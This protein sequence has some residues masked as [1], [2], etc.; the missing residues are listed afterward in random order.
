MS[1]RNPDNFNP[2]ELQASLEPLGIREITRRM[3]V[4]PLLVDQGNLARGSGIEGQDATICC[5]C[6]IPYE[7]L[8]KDG[9][10]P[11]P[12]VDGPLGAGGGLVNG[13]YG[14]Y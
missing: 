3:E 13:P 6:K 10:F 9:S 14:L 5:T 4:S 11:Y 12:T 2:A 1:H 8:L 7:D